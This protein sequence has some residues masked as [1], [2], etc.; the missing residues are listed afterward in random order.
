[1]RFTVEVDCRAAEGVGKETTAELA[2]SSGEIGG[3]SRFRK[4]ISPGVRLPV[5]DT[6]CELDA[7]KG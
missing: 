1:M 6:G 5:E 2:E 4:N 3:F 7:T